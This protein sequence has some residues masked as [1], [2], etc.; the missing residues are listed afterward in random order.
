MSVA[1]MRLWWAATCGVLAYILPLLLWVK[2]RSMYPTE[3]LAVP[4]LVVGSWW[5]ADT[6]DFRQGRVGF[7]FYGALP[8]A[9]GSNLLVLAV[10]RIRNF[11]S[12]RILRDVIL[13]IGSLVAGAVLQLVLPSLAE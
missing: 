12:R 3:L 7:T 1:E 9:V 8:A 13:V 4:A 10:L 2:R 6:F 5:L 11:Q